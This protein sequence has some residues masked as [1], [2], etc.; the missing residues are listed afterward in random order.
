MWEVLWKEP[1][2]VQI[3]W[4][5]TGI[6]KRYWYFEI[7]SVFW[8][9][10][11]SLKWYL[12]M[13]QNLGGCWAFL[14]STPNTSKRTVDEV[15]VEVHLSHLLFLKQNM[16]ELSQHPHQIVSRWDRTPSSSAA[17]HGRYR[18]H[19]STLSFCTISQLCSGIA[20]RKGHLCF[21]TS[22]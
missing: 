2:M 13:I 1:S 19:H 4:N 5:D 11:G 6:L 18:S 7:I 22:S 8:N 21:A 20:R 17:G 9:G 10:I 15:E 3:F 12:E 16:R 14:S